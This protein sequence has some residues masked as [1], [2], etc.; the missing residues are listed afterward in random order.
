MDDAR[1]PSDAGRLTPGTLPTQLAHFRILRR[2]DQ[3]GMGDV[4]LAHDEALD[5]PVA[6][7]VLPPELARDE[8]FVKRFHA[9]AAAIAKLGHPNVIRVDFIGEHAGQHFFVMQWIDGESLG[10]RLVRQPRLPLDDALGLAEQCLAGL[11]AVHAQ[12]LV[13]RDIKP[14]NV[15]IEART[16]RAVLVD[17]GLVRRLGAASD[18][19][20]T[21]VVLGTA[22]YI[23]PE[24]AR[25]LPVDTRADLYAF[26]VLLYQ[27]LAGRLPF[28]PA[29][30]STMRFQHVY[31]TPL[32]L[33]RTASA[34][35][36]SLA[37]IVERLL[38]TDP[39]DRYA[40]CEEVLAALRGFRESRRLAERETAEAAPSV[41]P[42]LSTRRWRRVFRHWQTVAGLAAAVFVVVSLLLITH[43]WWSP[44]Q[45]VAVSPPTPPADVATLT[46]Q[47]ATPPPQDA[48]A[49]ARNA[50]ASDT[51]STLPP[52]LL[53][54]LPDA[55]LENGSLDGSRQK[56][57]EFA[58][59]AVVG[60]TRYH[61][62]VSGRRAPRPV[63]DVS[64][65][66][67]TQ[68]SHRGTGY[69]IEANQRGWR[70]RVRALVGDKWTDWTEERTFDVGPIATPE[71]RA[72]SVPS[73][74]EP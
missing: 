18:L 10:Q 4:Y 8:T 65:I 14:A 45:T 29:S 48:T 58:W 27:M 50:T 52:K 25:G 11:A 57:W 9:E 59:S 49:S 21:G 28:E 37:S 31:G 5:R 13:H 61:L 33:A 47:A 1:E 19:T 41:W 70:W 54:P 62:F 55:V 20:V 7:K 23:A 6:I 38:A 73:G 67:H 64:E 40:N 39:V 46:A 26:G 24:Q 16:G 2:I 35:P 15:L 44:R 53:S 42:R 12:G 72:S 43:G 51:G 63:V 60:A 3:G 36:P 56:T 74:N 66:G 34:V 17:F 68:Y 69:V 32:P 30:A 22:D 71:S